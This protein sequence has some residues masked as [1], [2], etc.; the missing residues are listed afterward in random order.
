[1][2]DLSSGVAG[3]RL[4]APAH[5]R[6]PGACLHATPVV[7]VRSITSVVNG[8]FFRA[9]VGAGPGNGPGNGEA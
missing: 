8:T 4:R 7:S 3:R 2:G 6:F 9:P 5:R 1:M